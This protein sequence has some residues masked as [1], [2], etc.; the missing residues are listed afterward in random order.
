MEK[1]MNR[2]PTPRETRIIALWLKF[3]G[4]TTLKRSSTNV[5]TVRSSSHDGARVPIGT[6]QTVKNMALDWAARTLKDVS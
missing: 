5:M 1:L 6:D 4:Y 3:M 2:S